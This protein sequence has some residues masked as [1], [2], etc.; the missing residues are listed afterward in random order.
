MAADTT[1]GAVVSAVSVRATPF[2]ALIK[3]FATSFNA[4]DAISTTAAT[5]SPPGVPDIAIA[6]ARCASVNTNCTVGPVVDTVTV[7]PVNCTGDLPPDNC[8]RYTLPGTEKLDSS[9]SLIV[10]TRVPEP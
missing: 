2:A 10:R 5:P 4:P 8:D 6:D 3:L 9:T 7:A 1:V